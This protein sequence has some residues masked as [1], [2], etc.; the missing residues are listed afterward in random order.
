VGCPQTGK[1]FY[2]RN[3]PIGMKILSPTSGSPE[4]KGLV[5]SGGAPRESGFEGQWDLITGIPQ[6]WRNQKL[7]S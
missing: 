1:H 7:H 5:T 4:P 2:H 3:S 6:V